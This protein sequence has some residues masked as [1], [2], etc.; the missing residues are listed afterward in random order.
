V[1]EFQNFTLFV[2]LVMCGGSR[3]FVCVSV[4]AN[5]DRGDGGSP[6]ASKCDFLLSV[7]EIKNRTF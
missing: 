1:L 2:Y 3:V 5:K 6:E 4:G 7:K